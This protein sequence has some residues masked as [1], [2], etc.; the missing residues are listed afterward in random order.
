MYTVALFL[1]LAALSK[2]NPVPQAIDY[3]AVAAAGPIHSP[4]IAFGV[5]SQ[6]VTYNA[7]LAAESA[8]AQITAHPWSGNLQKRDGNCAPQPT[9]AGPTPSPDTASA[10]LAYQAFASVAS[11]AAVPSGYNSAFI[12]LQASNNAN[13]YMGFVTLSTYDTHLCAAKCSATSG[14]SAINICK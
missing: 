14:C 11:A 4:S 10:F 6:V 9:G 5:A 12:N 13:G 3:A 1:G 7:K 8:A 2:A